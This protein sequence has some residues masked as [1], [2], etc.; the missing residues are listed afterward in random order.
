[1]CSLVY[2]LLVA[3]NDMRAFELTLTD[4]EMHDLDQ[5]TGGVTVEEGFLVDVIKEFK[6]LEATFTGLHARP[7][8]LAPPRTS[9]TLTAPGRVEGGFGLLAVA[10]TLAFALVLMVTRRIA[11]RRHAFP[12]Y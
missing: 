7:H 9:W 4:K 3:E 1:L 8:K 12:L 10:L 6:D 5:I 2:P 11:A